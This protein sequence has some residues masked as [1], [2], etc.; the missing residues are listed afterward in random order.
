[1]TEMIQDLGWRSLAQRHADARLMLLHK[2]FKI[3]TGYV[4]VS[5]STAFQSL[6]FTFTNIFAM[7]FLTQM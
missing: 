1:M 3:V 2:I 4:A 6:G 7:D 5:S